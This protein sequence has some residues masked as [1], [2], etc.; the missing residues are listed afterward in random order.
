MTISKGCICTPNVASGLIL[1]DI[2]VIF[3]RRTLLH[4]VHG[5][6][7]GGAILASVTRAAALLATC[8][9]ADHVHSVHTSIGQVLALREGSSRRGGAE[10]TSLRLFRAGGQARGGGEVVSVQVVGVVQGE[11]VV[12]ALL[13]VVA[14]AEHVGRRGGGSR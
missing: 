5:H 3:G 14:S 1:I 9:V 8:R 2:H 12:G 11:R 6:L 10:Q 4:H 7:R 13:H